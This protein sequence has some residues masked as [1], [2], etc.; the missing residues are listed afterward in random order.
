MTDV[1]LISIKSRYDVAGFNMSEEN[2]FQAH[3]IFNSEAA[4]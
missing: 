2:H 1:L 4:T 3:C